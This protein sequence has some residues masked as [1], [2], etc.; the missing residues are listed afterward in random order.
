MID[1]SGYF[2]RPGYFSPVTKMKWIPRR[3][4]WIGATCFG[5][6]L[7]AIWGLWPLYLLQVPI[8]FMSDY[9]NTGKDS[10][11]HPA[12]RVLALFNSVFTIVSAFWAISW[13]EVCLLTI[14]TFTNYGCSVYCIKRQHFA[15]YKLAHSLWHIV[16]SVSIAYVTANACGVSTSFSSS[17]ERKWVGG[18]LCSCMKLG[19]Q[20][21]SA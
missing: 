3:S 10:W 4:L 5:Y 20:T 18:L 2:D 14:A 17:C 19:T 16:G 13:W 15:G 8:S 11:F 9:V 1:P 12:D 7:P 6:A 21:R